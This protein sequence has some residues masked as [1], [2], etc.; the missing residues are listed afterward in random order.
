MKKE[1]S[2]PV[3]LAEAKLMDWAEMLLRMESDPGEVHECPICGGKAHIE[4]EVY[5]SEGR[6]KV[7][8][9]I[10]CEGCQIVMALDGRGPIPAWAKPPSKLNSG[11]IELL[12]KS[13]EKRRDGT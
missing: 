6:K 9:Q 11:L 13:A 10:W 5:G 1:R 3:D 12:R 8:V 2:V 7:G 4:V